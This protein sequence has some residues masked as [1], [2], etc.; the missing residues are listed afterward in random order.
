MPLILSADERA[1]LLAAQRR[2]PGIRHWRRSQALVLRR[3]GLTV[4]QVAHA[5]GCT[6]TSI[7]N[8]TAAYRQAGVGGVGESAH[9]GAVRRLDTAGDA[10]LHALLTEGEP[11]AHG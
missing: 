3:D 5:L 1:G 4:A 10:T 6:E 9:P 2:R 8:W 7:Y 11:Q